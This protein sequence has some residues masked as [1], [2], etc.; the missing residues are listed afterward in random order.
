MRLLP[1]HSSMPVNRTRRCSSAHSR[2]KRR[3]SCSRPDC[4]PGSICW[5]CS[6]PPTRLFVSD[7]RT[8]GPAGCMFV[9]S[10][11]TLLP[12][13]CESLT[14]ADPCLS[15]ASKEFGPKLRSLLVSTSTWSGSLN[16]VET[17]EQPRSVLTNVANLLCPGP[18]PGEH[19]VA[20]RLHGRCWRTVAAFASS[21]VP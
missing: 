20:H 3:L 10:D 15:L 9:S 7:D 11:R 6:R 13:D 1:P 19:G 5:F 14:S 16:A 2:F 8:L 18:D 4:E 17:G 21:F 12:A